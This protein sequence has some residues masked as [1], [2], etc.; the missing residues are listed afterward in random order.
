[1]DSDAVPGKEKG[2]LLAR[3]LSRSS[4]LL[5]Y[6]PFCP[7]SCDI[8]GGNK[9]QLANVHVSPNLWALGSDPTSECKFLLL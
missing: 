8:V 4:L 5:E 7:L 2:P 1:M 6:S 9:I 3:H